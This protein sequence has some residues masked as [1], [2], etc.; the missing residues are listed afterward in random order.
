M[1]LPFLFIA[2]VPGRG[3]GVFTAEDIDRGVTLEVSPVIVM[4]REERTLLDQTLLHDYIFEWGEQKDQCCMALGYVPVYN[5]S[6]E[7]NCEYEMDYEQQQ[8]RIVTVRP[9]RAGE[10]LLINYNGDWNDATPVW[11]NVK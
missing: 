9:V 11:F 10:E 8:I 7:S 6:Y 1:V 4:S 2:P 5:H 3:R